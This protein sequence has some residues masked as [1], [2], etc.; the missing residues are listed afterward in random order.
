METTH[1]S[2]SARRLII[3]A[4]GLIAL[5]GGCSMPT[6]GSPVIE[7]IANPGRSQRPEVA[8]PVDPV[9]L[10]TLRERAVDLLNAA[11]TGENPQYRAN[12]IE[13]LSATPARL[14]RIAGPALHDQNLGVRSVAAIVIGRTGLCDLAPAV[15]PLLDDPSPFVRISAIYTLQR[16]DHRVDP[17]PLASYL[18]NDPS[19]RV[20]AHAAFV[21]GEL[22]N[23]S[24]LKLLRYAARPSVL[25]NGLPAEVRLYQLQLAEAMAKLGDEKQ[26]QT[27]RA[28][29]YPSRPEDLEATAL[30]VQI[31]GAIR[32]RGSIDQLIYLTAYRNEK[33][34]QMPAEVRLAAAASLAQLGYPQGSFIADEFYQSEKAA[35]RG[36]AA[37]V[38]GEI[39]K[40]ENLAKL[41]PML[42]DPDGAVR[43]AAAAAILKIASRFSGAG[44]G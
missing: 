39:G 17:T 13:A 7:Q 23:P 31:L 12:A 38:Y 15:R 44:I 5:A 36:Q 25:P 32:D 41:E 11:A 37:F 22:G 35:L 3:G 18:I 6:G 26:L 8:A 2:H 27:L 29:L 28:A 40:A 24:A 43:V 30:A 42:E 14:E 10:S 4:I 21:L 16:C 9:A 1:G 20:R 33:S 19:P 34:Q